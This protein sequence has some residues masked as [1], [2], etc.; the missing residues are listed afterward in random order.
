MEYLNLR[1]KTF[2]KCRIENCRA[3]Q[4]LPSITPYHHIHVDYAI[5]CNTSWSNHNGF[6]LNLSPSVSPR[7]V[8]GKGIILWQVFNNLTSE[9]TGGLRYST[10]T[11]TIQLY[12]YAE[13]AHAPYWGFETSL[14]GQLFS[15][16]TTTFGQ[17]PWRA[18]ILTYYFP[19]FVKIY[20]RHKTEVLC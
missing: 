11:W 15:L 19:N 13:S 8:S 12:R 5:H 6:G 1:R 14:P 3:L 16:I 4:I 20:T 18:T 2:Y 7:G 10:L 17:P 9:T